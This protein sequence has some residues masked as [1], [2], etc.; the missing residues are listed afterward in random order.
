MFVEKHG[1][2]FQIKEAETETLS[3]FK[4]L[5]SLRPPS[6]STVKNENR[7]NLRVKFAGW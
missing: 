3:S 7:R 4:I 1:F 6:L 5:E 2:S